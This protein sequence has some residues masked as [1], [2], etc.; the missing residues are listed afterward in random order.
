[1]LLLESTTGGIVKTGKTAILFTPRESRGY[2]ISC[3]VEGSQ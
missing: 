3:V 1:M 2:R